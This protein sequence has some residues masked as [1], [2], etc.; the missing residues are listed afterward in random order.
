[1]RLKTEPSTLREVMRL[2]QRC[3]DE[4]G[5]VPYADEREYIGSHWEVDAAIKDA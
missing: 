1:M 2:R 3:L 4:P 5:R